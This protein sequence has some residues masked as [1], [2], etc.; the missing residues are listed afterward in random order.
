MAA[1]AI[2]MATPSQSS[3]LIP[4]P[5]STSRP[6]A[7][8][9]PVVVFGQDSRR[10]TEA[11][12][13]DHHLDAAQVGRSHVASGL[14]QCGD[15]HGAGQLTLSDNVIT[16]AAHVFYD[17]T[18]L[19]RSH[20]CTFDVTING[21]ET[22]VPIDFSSI[23]AGSTNPYD[24]APVHDWA[25]ARLTHGLTGVKPYGLAEEVHA[26]ESITFVARG[27]IEWGWC[28]SPLP[29]AMPDAQSACP[30]R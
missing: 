10:T 17:E 9:V 8:I 3:S 11:F 23:V 30:G 4:L 15:A 7:S 14:I 5:F 21:R 12:A 2:A 24:V 6:A 20:S 13:V 1:L 19:A 18:G 22:R 25:V 29:P 27:H 26:D 16:T 28:Q